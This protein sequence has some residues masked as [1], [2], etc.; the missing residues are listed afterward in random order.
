MIDLSELVP[1]IVADQEGAQYK[2]KAILQEKGEAFDEGKVFPHLK[3]IARLYRRINKVLSHA[4]RLETELR[5]HLDIQEL[6]IAEGS[7]K[8]EEID[9]GDVSSI[10]DFLR[11]LHTDLEELASYGKKTFDAAEEGLS[12][13]F[14]GPTERNLSQGYFLLHEDCFVP[15]E[16]QKRVGHLVFEY[17]KDSMYDKDDDETYHRLKSDLVTAVSLDAKADDMREHLITSELIGEGSTLLSVESPTDHMDN[18][19]FPLEGTIKPIAK[20]L[21]MRKITEAANR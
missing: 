7:I 2:V 10:T 9:M 1:M 15:Y 3:E 8:H 20:R 11:N 19:G 17:R 14:I 6:D 16:R 5:Q 12:V 4:D 21:V 18:P 13:R